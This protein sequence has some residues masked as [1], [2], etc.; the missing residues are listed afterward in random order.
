MPKCVCANPR[1]FDK[2]SLQSDTSADG[3]E[4]ESFTVAVGSMPC[5]IVTVGGVETYKGR[6]LKPT[7]SH[8]VETPYRTGVVATQRVIPSVGIYK[9]R[10]LN[11]ESVRPM[12]TDGQR[13]VLEL[14]CK[15][16]EP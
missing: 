16:L 4:L 14:Y 3:A 1:Y 13:P 2:A 7:I 6:Q 15:E 12:R 8:V 9:D 10:I 5:N 11:I